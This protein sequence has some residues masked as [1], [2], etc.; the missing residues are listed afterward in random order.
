MAA[1]YILLHSPFSALGSTPVVK[2]T[3]IAVKHWARLLKIDQDDILA[4]HVHVTQECN[5]RGR[6]VKV[7]LPCVDAVEHGEK[8]MRCAGWTE[9]EIAE[10]TQ[11]LATLQ[12]MVHVKKRTRPAPDLDV[13]AIMEPY[14]AR[15]EAALVS[16][17]ALDE[18]RATPEYKEQCERSVARRVAELVAYQEASLTLELERRRTE[19]MARLQSELDVL[20]QAREKQMECEL[21]TRR[22]RL[23]RIMLGLE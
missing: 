1:Q 15:V 21:A 12:Q 18:F 8:L 23:E 14:T 2:R 4:L 6:G 11:Q 19:L 20:R 5:G 3:F 16:A 13:H 7:A 22:A 10:G 9:H 17:R